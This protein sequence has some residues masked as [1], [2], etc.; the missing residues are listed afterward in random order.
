MWKVKL[1]WGYD[2]L[3]GERIRIVTGIG[4]GVGRG[5]TAIRMMTGIG[6]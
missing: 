3:Q 4:V 2:Q 5:G 1:M 6:A